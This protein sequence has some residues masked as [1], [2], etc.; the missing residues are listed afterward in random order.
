[1]EVVVGVVDSFKWFTV[2]TMLLCILN[3][4][5][6]IGCALPLRKRYRWFGFLPGLGILIAA[7]SMI[8]GD[9]S[10][11]ALVLYG[12]TGII[13]IGTLKLTCH[14]F[15]RGKGKSSPGKRGPVL[16]AT[17]AALCVLGLAPIVLALL[18]AGETRYNPVSELG[19]MSY[20]QA[21]TAM[22]DRLSRE[23]PFGAWKQIDWEQLEKQYKPIFEQADQEQDKTLYYKTLRHY[24]FGFRDG[25]VRIVN[26][27]LFDGNDIFKREAGG[28]FGLSAAQL[29]TGKIR[30]TLV[31]KDSPADKSGIKT[32]AELLTWDGIAATEAFNEASWSETPAAT[33]EVKRINQGRFMVRGVV[34]QTVQV[35][36]QNIGEQ[37]TSRAELIAYDDQFETLK[38]TRPKLKKED[39]PLEAKMLDNGY[40][41]M[42]IRHFLAEEI[43][44]GPG[45]T[46]EQQLR[47]FQANQA[48]GVIL[49]LRDNPG[50]ADQL[51]AKL[52]EYFTSDKT[53]YEHASYYNRNRG[54][55]ELNRP[56]TR[57][58][59]PSTK[60]NF[61][62]KI[63]ILINNRTASSGEGVPLVLKGRSNVKIVGFTSTAASF[64]LLSAPIE[65]EMPEGYVVQFPD[66][67]SLNYSQ[68]IQVDSDYNGK[69]GVAPDVKVPL[70]E[71]TFRQKYMDGQDVEL[72]YAIEALEQIK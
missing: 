9:F 60:V 43:F 59:N 49:D 20:S 57:Y 8:Y 23:Y 10:L 45:Q 34:G 21:F 64:G 29:D 72:N 40:G 71:E 41:Y 62:G 25:H 11:T 56:E 55:F 31:V 42:K 12:L 70:N 6:L 36:F 61:T 48:K 52:A 44:T 32:G 50:G 19:S 33:D 47:L 3:V 28:G 65:F 26:E 63:A 27:R 18:Y 17:I 39:A 53:F 4:V 69:G 58:V 51:A 67:R 46:V 16:A 68:I 22:N 1:M 37:E 13:F 38:Q 15:K 35:E 24:L 5:I 54:E 66:G 30:V 2:F 14:A 7:A